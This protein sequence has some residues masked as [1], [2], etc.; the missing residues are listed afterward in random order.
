[1]G[2]LFWVSLA[3]AFSWGLGAGY[4]LAYLLARRSIY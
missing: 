4:W 3:L 1:M 2:A